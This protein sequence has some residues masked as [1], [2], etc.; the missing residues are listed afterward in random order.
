LINL[1]VEKI[2]DATKHQQPVSNQ[3]TTMNMKQVFVLLGLVIVLAYCTKTGVV[4]AGLPIENNLAG[5]WK[6]TQVQGPGTGTLGSWS[7]ADPAGQTMIIGRNGSISGT[8]FAAATGVEKID[9]FRIRITDPTVQPGYRLF[10]YQLDNLAEMLFL[11]IQPTN[12]TLCNEGCGGYRFE[13]L[14]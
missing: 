11:Y 14:D 5:K 8:A 12:G 4:S 9:S 3:K 6:L 2:P 7:P 10:H 1:P 13:R